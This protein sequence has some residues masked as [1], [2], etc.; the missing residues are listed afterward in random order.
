MAVPAFAALESRVAARTLAMLAN[1]RLT[2]GTLTF[3]ALLD[4]EAY[5]IGLYAEAADTRHVMTLAQADFEA[6]AANAVIAYDPASYTSAWIAA[7][8]RNN[9]VIDKIESRDGNLVKV[10]LA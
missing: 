7:Q 4:R 8:P 1:A 5:P 2:D 3:D 9:W 10:W 6:L